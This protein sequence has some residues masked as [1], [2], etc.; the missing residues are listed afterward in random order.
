MG[1]DKEN[2]YITIPVHNRKETTLKCLETLKQNGDL[3]KYYVIVIDDGSTDGTSE[4]IQSLYPDVIILTGDGNLWWTGAIKKGMEYAYEKGADYFIWLND[5]CYPQ[6]QAI[7]KLLKVCQSNSQFIAGG[8]CLDPNDFTPTYGGILT[9]NNHIKEAQS[10][11]DETFTKCD[12]LNGNFACISKQVVQN[13]GYPDSVK[14]PHHF[15]DFVYTNKA[16]KR[17][18][19]LFLCNE[20]NAFCK[21]NNP[22]VSWI[23]PDRPLIEYWQ[24]Y[25]KPNSPHYWKIEL[26]AYKELLDW[27]GIWGYFY[28][29]HIKFWI[30][31]LFIYPLPINLKKKLK[32]R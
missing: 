27:F 5:D 4:A 8:K 6:K 31:Y 11:S 26:L 21:N 29:K 22:L 3:D 19:I 17:G 7:S 2:V 13:I 15:G 25:F 30:I 32:S 12:A 10:L 28:Q 24:D 1:M 20:I 9:K 18:Y 16:K 23:F 14:F